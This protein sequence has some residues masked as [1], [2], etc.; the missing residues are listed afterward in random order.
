M[1]KE[2]ILKLISN[3]ALLADSDVSALC[4]L[5]EAFPASAPIQ[6]LYL[7]GLQKNQSYLYQKQLKRAALTIPSRQRLFDFLQD[8][9]EFEGNQSEVHAS[10]ATVPQA[11]S[12][13]T[14]VSET[15][16]LAEVAA[17]SQDDEK[18]T[19]PA[20]VVSDVEIRTSPQMEASTGVKEK[21]EEVS[22]EKT[23]TEASKNAATEQL[24]ADGLKGHVSP[25]NLNAA[26]KSDG[27]IQPEAASKKTTTNSEDPATAAKVLE[28]GTVAFDLDRVDARTRAVIERSLALR[29]KLAQKKSAVVPS[30]EEPKIEE[31]RP[32]A[33]V[34]SIEAVA[35]EAPEAVSNQIEGKVSE[36]EELHENEGA[37]P[38][39]DI[40]EDHQDWEMP[41]SDEKAAIPADESGA[42]LSIAEHNE[43]FPLLVFNANEITPIPSEN[44]AANLGEQDLQDEKP[45]EGWVQEIKEFE[46]AELPTKNLAQEQ[47]NETGHTF[48]EWIQ[49]LEQ[50]VQPRAKVVKASSDKLQLI[51]NFLKKVPALKPTKEVYQTKEIKSQPLVESPREQLMTETL[52]NVY[53][54]QKHYDKAIGAFEILRLKYPEK[55][56]YFADLILKVRK[57]K[58]SPE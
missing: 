12:P 38:V 8:P 39:V 57:L 19:G 29:A 23:F 10:E 55:S 9:T 47:V 3:P 45:K 52:A 17:T 36:A 24:I 37:V 50:G 30:N 7:K 43:P 18:S 49:L 33:P 11:S 4:D 15:P 21:P 20:E 1:N 27:E 25:S 51:D 16:K 2:R 34:V 54:A 26:S 5:A 42:D 14:T 40:L 56:S 31:S 44:S 35:K 48:F 41:E 53:L 28:D 46:E 32:V 22:K 13:K 58:N 6:M